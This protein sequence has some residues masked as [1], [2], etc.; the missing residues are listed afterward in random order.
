MIKPRSSYTAEL[1]RSSSGLDLV[2][3]LRGHKRSLFHCSQWEVLIF[4]DHWRKRT[5]YGGVYIR[6]SGGAKLA[7]VAVACPI[8]GIIS[9][10]R[11][12]IRVP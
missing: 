6:D 4:L 12:L 7:A 1:I 8:D 11:I 5:T 3:Y 2:K 9:Q 10:A